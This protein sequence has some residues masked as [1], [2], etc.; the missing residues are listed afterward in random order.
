MLSCCHWIT[1]FGACT[2]WIVPR[3]AH[4]QL[5]QMMCLNLS[6]K[7]WIGF[8]PF[9]CRNLWRWLSWSIGAIHLTRP[10]PKGS[11]EHD[12]Y[13]SPIKP[14]W[15]PIKPFSY[16]SGLRLLRVLCKCGKLDTLCPGMRL[17]SSPFWHQRSWCF[18]DRQKNQ[19]HGSKHCFRLR[20]TSLGA[21][22]D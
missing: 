18:K 2:L 17:S 19:L 10:I 11:K 13:W 3:T 21:Y 16:F 7:N 12:P 5:N 9:R 15:Y 1:W 4:F 14:F 22:A 20:V 6:Q 8:Q